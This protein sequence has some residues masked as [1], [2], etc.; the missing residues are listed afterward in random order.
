MISQAYTTSV[1]HQ[2]EYHRQNLSVSEFRSLLLS[3]TTELNSI[4]ST[5][6]VDDQDVCISP[7]KLS[8]SKRSW[9]I[10]LKD[11]IDCCCCIILRYIVSVIHKYQ[12]PSV[13]NLWN[14]ILANSL[15][16][17]PQVNRRFDYQIK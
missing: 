13:E 14:E 10:A 12:I 8:T 6:S 9:K 5:K 4:N 3:L 17:N 1:L 11:Q 16:E 15:T 2:L 7:R